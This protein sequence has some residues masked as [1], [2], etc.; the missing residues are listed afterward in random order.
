LVLSTSHDSN[1][2]R[3]TFFVKPVKVEEFKANVACFDMGKNGRL[4]NYVKSKS[5]ASLRKQTSA[6]F[7]PTCHYCGIVSHIRPNYI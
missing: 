2:D 7:V 3:K 4:N 6:K 1:F 5:K